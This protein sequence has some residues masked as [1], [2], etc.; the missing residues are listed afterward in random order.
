ME[1]PDGSI[2]FATQEEIDYY[3]KTHQVCHN[4]MSDY[5]FS[6]LDLQIRSLYCSISTLDVFFSFFIYQ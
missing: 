2:R 3:D 1:N 4:Y 6:R 5:I